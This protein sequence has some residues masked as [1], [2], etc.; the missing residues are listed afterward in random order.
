MATNKKNSIKAWLQSLQMDEM[1]EPPIPPVPPV[2][3]VPRVPPLLRPFPPFKPDADDRDVL[4]LLSPPLPDN[5]A[6]RQKTF[7]LPTSQDGA[8]SPPSFPISVPS[9]PPAAPPQPR[10]PQPKKSPPKWPLRSVLKKT[11]KPS[12][13]ATGAQRE[14]DAPLQQFACREDTVVRFLLLKAHDLDPIDDRDTCYP[15][16]IFKLG[17][18]KYTSKPSLE[19]V[20]SAAR[21]FNM[22]LADYQYHATYEVQQDLD[23]NAGR[24]QFR[25][26]LERV[27][28]EEY[29]EVSELPTRQTLAILRKRIAAIY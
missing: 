13:D 21:R 24:V 29:A 19:Y 22:N 5:K 8:S 18:E 17:K 16:V 3:P 9:T 20:G 2:P 4:P 15:Y 25:M 1:P 10:S 7:Q 27:G 26:V 14:S 11:K 23:D 12:V 28:G 6:P